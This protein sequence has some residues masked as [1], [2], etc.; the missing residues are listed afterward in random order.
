MI[1][2]RGGRLKR[3]GGLIFFPPTEKGGFLE[4]GSLFGRGGGGA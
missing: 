1:K 3:E 2:E 4:M